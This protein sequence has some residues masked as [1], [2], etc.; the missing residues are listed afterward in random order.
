MSGVTAEGSADSAWG[1]SGMP[2]AGFEIV[3]MSC[4]SHNYFENLIKL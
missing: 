4:D 2:G 1:E 3:L